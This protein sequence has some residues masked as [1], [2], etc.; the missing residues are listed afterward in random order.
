MSGYSHRERVLLALNHHQP[1]R[2]PFDMMGNATMLLDKT[3][4]NLCDHLGLSPIPPIRKGTTTNYYDER[5]LEYFDIDLRRVFLKKNPS[6]PSTPNEQ[7]V[8]MDPWGVKFQ[9]A[10]IYVNALNHPLKDATTV[11]EIENFHWPKASDVFSA[12]GLRETASRL[13]NN[14][15]YAIVARNPLSL[16]FLDKACQLMGM[17]DFMIL[18]MTAPEAAQCLLEHLLV[19]YKD[20]Y[21]I[22]LSASGEYVQVVE[23]ADDIGSQDS[24]L[25]SPELYRKFVK[26][27]EREFYNLIKE[28]A[29]NAYIFRH[30]D[31]AIFDI[32]P[33]LIEVGVDILNPVQTSAKGMQAMRLKKNFG[34][35]ITFHGAIEKMESPK[36]QLF[37]QVKRMIEDLSPGGGYIFASCNHMVD[38]K[39][40]NIIVMFET[41]LKYGKY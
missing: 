26:P 20:T 19:F 10:G 32:I 12:E 3:Y 27:C 15:D 34:N 37:E 31:G 17:T 23:T 24:L 40:E 5:I 41:A 39:P 35:S 13:Y 28:K 38:V 9:M 1:D 8:W 6:N 7:G 14:T 16:G 29:P 25:I 22:F 30:N 33:D 18:I 4:L 21:D 2:I 11:K 36:D